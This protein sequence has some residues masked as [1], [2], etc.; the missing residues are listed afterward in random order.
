MISKIFI[1]IKDIIKARKDY[2]YTGNSTSY[3]IL[4]FLYF[5]SDGLLLKFI[6]F[7]I[8]KKKNKKNFSFLIFNQNST[9]TY[10]ML[11]KIN[12]EE[13]YVLR[14]EI[15]KMKIIENKSIKADLKFINNY[16]ND[17]NFLNFDYYKK[18]NIVRLDFDKNQLIQNYVVTN[19]VKNLLNSNLIENTENFFN[20]EL[21]MLGINSWITLPIP[22]KNNLSSN[23]NYD[24]ITNFYD[25]QQWHRD[26]DNL[27][28]IKIFIY[29]TDVNNENDG[30]FQIIINSNNF[31]YFSPFKYR[32]YRSLRVPN[33]YIMNKYKLNVHSF[34]G[35]KGTNFIADTR[36]LHRGLAITEKKTRFMLEIYFSNHSLG[37][38]RK[39]E[40]KTEHASFNI[41]KEMVNENYKLYS[42]LFK[43]ETL[44]DLMK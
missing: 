3:H 44:T 40:I 15:T 4:R 43:K 19:F 17:L 35:N 25:A 37:K 27:R 13:I 10:K 24:S 11:K 18:K 22:L 34:F 41:W 20:T 12:D 31:T 33:S 7:F 29:L 23:A 28:D 30:C 14:D 42:T 8:I 36:A 26:C 6:E 2:L 21:H 39:L 9:P 16:S 5:L 1:F 38:D 32:N